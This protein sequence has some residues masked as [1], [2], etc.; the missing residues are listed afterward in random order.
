M[1]YR[2]GCI[3]PV[4]LPKFVDE[5]DYFCQLISEVLTSIHC[6]VSVNDVCS[7]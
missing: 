6:A 4:C 3:S 2:D 5:K 1:C 7:T